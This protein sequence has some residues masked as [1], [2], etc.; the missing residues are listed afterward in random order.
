MSGRKKKCI[1]EAVFQEG[2][3]IVCSATGCILKV[4]GVS[5]DN[6]ENYF[7]NVAIWF[8]P[9]PVEGMEYVKGEYYGYFSWLVEDQYRK[10]TEMEVLLLC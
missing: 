8:D 2:D 1:T 4:L 6:N 10:A 7:Y 5:T 9:C 3:F